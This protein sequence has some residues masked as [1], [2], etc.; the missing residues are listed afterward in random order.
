MAGS[1]T[2]PWLSG[3]M[4]VLMSP[5]REMSPSSEEFIARVGS[6]TSAEDSAGMSGNLDIV[7]SD[8]VMH[9]TGGQTR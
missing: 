1:R 7:W 8:K 4:M 5:D 2:C 3:V 6:T 9:T